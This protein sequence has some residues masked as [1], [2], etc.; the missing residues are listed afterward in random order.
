MVDTRGRFVWYE[1]MTTDVDAARA[2]YS[3]VVGWST[4]DV[5]APG[6]PYTLFFAGD[7]AVG[8]LLHLTEEATQNGTL[9]RW[10]GYVEVSDVD[11]AAGKVR[12]LGGKIYVPPTNIGEISRLAVV[13]DPQ[14]ALFALIRWMVPRT[15]PASAQRANG[16]IGW[17]ELFANNCEQALAFYGDLFGW[18]KTIAKSG[19]LGTYHLFASREQTIGG[20]LTKPP[21]LPVPFWLHYF[22]VGDIDAAVSRVTAG[23]GRIVNG[24]R[25]APDGSWIVQC[26]DPQ[27]A[28][29]A[30]IGKRSHAVGFLERLSGQE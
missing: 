11:A 3:D 9:P 30:L 28:I 18:R 27:D 21:S 8:G 12:A 15:E 16:R 22:N 6:M 26:T 1:L 17:H 4:R 5:S 19:E 23:G 24:P 7:D 10:L 20:V 29:F 14:H 13:A 25:Q 2:F